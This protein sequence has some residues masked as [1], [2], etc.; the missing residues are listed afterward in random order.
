MQ[1]FCEQKKTDV[2]WLIDSF[3]DELCID[4]G[5]WTHS[6]GNFSSCYTDRA[7]LWQLHTSIPAS[8]DRCPVTDTSSYSKHHGIKLYGLTGP[9]QSAPEIQAR[10]QH[11]G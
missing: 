7:L 5:D 11:L 3:I 6:W 1:L 2:S 10:F 8:Q 9:S 4:F